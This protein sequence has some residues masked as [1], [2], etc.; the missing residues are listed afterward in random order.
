MTASLAIDTDVLAI[1]Y[2]F[3]RDKRYDITLDFLRKSKKQR[4]MITLY[5]LLEL[6][7]LLVIGANVQVA[8]RVY[9]QLLSI[10]NLMVITHNLP[11]SWGEFTE[12]IMS[13]INRKIHFSDALIIYTLESNGVDVFVTWNKRHFENKIDCEVLTPEEW[14]NKYSK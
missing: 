10:D 7:G 12:N 13:V 4:R 11:I 2:L 9:K 3:K 14:L 5:N 1:A 6:Y 8:Q